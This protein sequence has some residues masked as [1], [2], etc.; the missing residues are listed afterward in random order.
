MQN[1]Y[2]NKI[3]SKPSPLE[4]M[5]GKRCDFIA[6]CTNYNFEIKYINLIITVYLIQ[7]AIIL[8]LW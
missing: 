4:K 8:L 3:S 5:L 2:Y 7:G 1:D 6:Y